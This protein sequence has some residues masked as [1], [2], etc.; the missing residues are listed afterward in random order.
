MSENENKETSIA[1]ILKTINK[2]EG[3]DPSDFLIDIQDNSGRSSKYL[4]VKDRITWFR[5]V[6]PSGRIK[7]GIINLNEKTII[8]EAEISNNDGKILANAT[9]M[10]WI[11]QG[12]L[13]G[14]RAAECAE[15]AAVGRALLFAGFGTQASGDDL[16]ETPENLA[17]APIH[18]HGKTGEARIAEI[19]KSMKTSIA[20]GIIIPC[21]K[22]QGQTFKEMFKQGHPEEIRYFADKYQ[23]KTETQY[24]L[25]AAAKYLIKRYDEKIKS[26]TVREQCVS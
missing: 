19:E 21:G 26:K 24:Q 9:A 11:D 18:P 1:K 17:D 12:D 15:T 8:M 20:N 3:F 23:A 6:Y 5:L 22:Y 10:A 13:F 2:V 4:P 7:T 14:K 16:A 25:V